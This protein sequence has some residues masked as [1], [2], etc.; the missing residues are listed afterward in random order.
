MPCFLAGRAVAEAMAAVLDVPVVETSHQDGH[1]MAALYSSGNLDALMTA[2]FAAFHVSGGTTE[3]LYVKPT[4]TAFDI[5]LI[6]ESNDLNAGQAID[7]VG[8]M[9]GL[10]F[11]CG[12]EIEALA[13]TYTG[14]LP[15]PRVSVKDGVCNL[16]GLQNL[17]EKL[18]NE[19]QDKA[20]VSA[21][22]LRFV[23]ETLKR[24]TDHIDATYSPD[25]PIIYAGGVMS[26]RYLQSVLSARAN[27][28]FAEPQFSA[29]NA[30]G[31]A[32]LCRRAFLQ[33]NP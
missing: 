4:E 15:K 24:M 5:T 23:G 28:Y 25:L 33:Q 12:K 27:T 20:A 30:A 8:V 22:V 32:L 26:N 31:V 13:A 2:P 14:K 21:F 7:R 9:M 6:G 16:S 11:P 29:D 1:V 17:A 10:Q 3:M 19:T 18:W